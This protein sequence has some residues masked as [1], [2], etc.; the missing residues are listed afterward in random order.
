MNLRLLA[1]EIQEALLF[2]PRTLKGR[3]PLR[4]AD[5]QRVAAQR[6][7]RI[8]RQLWQQLSESFAELR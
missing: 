4:L 7:W 2:L 3:D 8:Q 1:P 5:L 6:D